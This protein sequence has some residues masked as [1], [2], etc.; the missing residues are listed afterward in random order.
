[1]RVLPNTL[2]GTYPARG[3]KLVQILTFDEAIVDAHKKCD[4]ISVLLGNGFSIDYDPAIFAYDSLANEADLAALSIDKEALFE[5]LGSSNFEVVID[6]LCSAVTIE[7]L[8]GGDQDLADRLDAD[9]LAVR[10]GLAD[11]LAARHPE[12]AL[13]L[14]DDEAFHAREFLSNFRRIFTLSYDLLLY[15]VMNRVTPGV[16]VVKSDGFE[17]PSFYDRDRLIWKM[18]PSRPQRVFFLHGALHMFVNEKR[19]LTKISYGSDGSLVESLR[20]RLDALDYPLI[21]TEGTRVEK[22][23]R[24]DKSSYLRAGLRRLGE[25]EGG[26]FVHGVSLSPNDDHILEQI[27]AETSLVRALYV[28]IHGDARSRANRE[29]MERAQAI[30]SRRRY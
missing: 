21:V 20:E 27:E 22:E 11:V 1:M 19:R 25:I 18:K 10:N 30:K 24:I 13:S 15:W 2:V 4:E 5:A 3:P 23:A 7:R 8:Y 28:S 14:T 16:H 9:A 12:S 17:W 6:K 29:L 26:L